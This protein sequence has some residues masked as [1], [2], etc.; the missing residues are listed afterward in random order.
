[1]P[2]EYNPDRDQ[3]VCERCGEI[4][5]GGPTSTG[6]E[7]HDHDSAGCTPP[8]AENECAICWETII[9]TMRPD[10]DVIDWTH[11]HGSVHC[12]TG[13]GAVATPPE[14]T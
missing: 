3:R 7:M 11:R 4:F 2:G 6:W 14:A 5:V 13:D 8:P 9:G 12:W 10:A 1:M